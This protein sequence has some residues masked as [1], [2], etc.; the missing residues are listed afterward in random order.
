LWQNVDV[1]RH[2]GAQWLIT[3]GAIGRRHR[4]EHIIENA[5]TT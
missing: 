1:D 2:P 4:A 5:Q 3:G